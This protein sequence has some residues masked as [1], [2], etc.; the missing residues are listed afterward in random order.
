VPRVRGGK[1]FLE[2]R[3]G[4]RGGRQRATSTTEVQGDG[5]GY[6]AGGF[7]NWCKDMHCETSRNKKSDGHLRRETQDLTKKRPKNKKD[8]ILEK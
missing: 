2:C 5:W 6:G 7:K 8:P 3:E 4:F 1:V